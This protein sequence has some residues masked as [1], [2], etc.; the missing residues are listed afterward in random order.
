MVPFAP[1]GACEGRPFIQS[2][3]GE[4]GCLLRE[5]RKLP[6]GAGNRSDGSSDARA[7][8]VWVRENMVS[9]EDFVPPCA[10]WKIDMNMTL[11]VSGST[12]ESLYRYAE[13]WCS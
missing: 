12:L 13:D 6:R 1:K 2:A 3:A 7:C 4:S 10:A 5:A 11:W 9:A 8:V